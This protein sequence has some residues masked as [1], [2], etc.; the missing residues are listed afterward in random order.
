MSAGA[1]DL[2]TF[3]KEKTAFKIARRIAGL[4]CSAI[5]AVA[6]ILFFLA[7][8]SGI[9]QLAPS[10]PTDGWRFVLAASRVIFAAGLLYSMYWQVCVDGYLREI[11]LLKYT[12]VDSPIEQFVEKYFTWSFVFIALA[13]VTLYL[14]TLDKPYWHLIAAWTYLGAIYFVDA[15]YSEKSATDD[16]HNAYFLTKPSNVMKRFT[17]ELVDTVDRIAYWAAFLILVA[18]Y[19]PE[20]SGLT[21]PAGTN[22]TMIAEVFLSGAIAFQLIVTSFLVRRVLFGW[23]DFLLD[24]ATHQK[25][26]RSGAN[27]PTCAAELCLQ[28]LVRA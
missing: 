18:A 14:I 5:F 21:F 25:S 22:Y 26:M 11:E 10:A 20:F 3:Y 24:C 17:R 15:S 28:A 13:M 12:K 4:K 27:P 23:N 8:K 16:E 19:L 2:V 7:S 9:S 6:V 1:V